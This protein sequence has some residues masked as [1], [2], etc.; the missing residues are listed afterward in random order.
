AR[1]TLPCPATAAAASL[2]TSAAASGRRTSHTPLEA[3]HTGLDLYFHGAGHLVVLEKLDLA[4]AHV[5]PGQY[6]DGSSALWVLSTALAVR[7]A[8]HR[9][10]IVLPQNR[11]PGFE[12]HQILSTAGLEQLEWGNV[13]GDPNRSPVRRHNQ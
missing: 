8:A 3:I 1:R 11:C 2:E 6:A 9:L 5:R 10:R 12:Q 7:G 13:V 4:G